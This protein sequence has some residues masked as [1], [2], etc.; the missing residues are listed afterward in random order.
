M[1]ASQTAD[2]QQF[3]AARGLA[4]PAARS[5]LLLRRAEKAEQVFDDNT[6]SNRYRIR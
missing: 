3:A 2:R 1:A 6:P 4:I 5:R